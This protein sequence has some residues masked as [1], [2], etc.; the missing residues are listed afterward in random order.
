MCKCYVKAN[1]SL[2]AT[3]YRLAV[4]FS[5]SKDMSSLQGR[6]LITTE[7]LHDFKGKRKP[8]PVVSAAYCPFCGEKDGLNKG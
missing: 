5:M 4:G 1:E 7:K 3:G 6:L 2:A 8:A